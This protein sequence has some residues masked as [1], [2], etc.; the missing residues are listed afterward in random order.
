MIYSQDV[1]SEHRQIS[2]NFLK[3]MVARI[4]TEN[5]IFFSFTLLVLM[6]PSPLWFHAM[7]K[8]VTNFLQLAVTVEEVLYL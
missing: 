6:C 2:E 8:L 3:V 4:Y 1:C 5:L 7:P